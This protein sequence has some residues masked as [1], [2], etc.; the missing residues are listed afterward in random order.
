MVDRQ[1][2]EIVQAGALIIALGTNISAVAESRQAMGIEAYGDL[3]ATIGEGLQA[4]GAFVIGTVPDEGILSFS[5]NWIDGIGAATSSVGSYLALTNTVDRD[6]SERI[7]VIGDSFQSMGASMSALSDYEADNVNSAR[8]NVT[9]ALGAGL[10]AIGTLLIINDNP[11][12]G[13]LIVAIGSTLQ[14]IGANYIARLEW[15]E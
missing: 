12:S 9:Q 14:A 1:S 13:Q 10:E 3:L 2:Q 5:G 4:V 7:I 11:E 6:Q 8:G 15:G